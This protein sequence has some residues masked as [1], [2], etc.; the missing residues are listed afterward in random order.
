MTKDKARRVTRSEL[1]VETWNKL[2]SESLGASELEEI[3]KALVSTFGESGVE[4]PASIARTL[5]DTGVTLRHPEI[6]DFDSAWR[7]V[8]SFDSMGCGDLDF[9]TI[10]AT[11]VSLNTLS[12]LL[13]RLEEQQDA[14]G[15]A[16]FRAMVAAIRQQL[17]LLSRSKAVSEL[18]KKAAIEADQWL[19]IWL[20]NPQI[21]E[22]W[23]ELRMNSEEFRRVFGK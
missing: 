3:Q 18:R 9:N 23:R 16:T 12:S 4:G 1:V 21:F 8:H 7:D 22:D 14:R 15:K 17:R 5:A 13:D 2:N 6:L 20:Q 10:E 11:V 19:G